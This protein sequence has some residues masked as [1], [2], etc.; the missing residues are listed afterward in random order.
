VAVVNETFAKRFFEGEDPLGKRYC[1]GQPSGDKTQWWTIVGVVGDMRRTGFD[2]DVRPETFFPESQNPDIALNIVARTAGDP[3]SYASALRDAI[4]SVD[5]D[6]PVFDIK[7]MDATLVE[8]T[9][10]RRFNMLLLGIFAA[11]ALLLAA[12]GLYGVMS[13]SVTQ[14]M[15]ELGVRI[16]LGASAR[17]VM[18]LVVGY[19]MRLALVG[20]GVGLVAAFFLTQLMGSLLYGVSATDPATFLLISSLLTGVSLAASYVPARRAMNVDPMIAL[21]YE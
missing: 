15:H 7:T 6:Q 19:A 20:V 9:A 10:Q 3:A 1:Y 12:V 14:R 18:R 11:V 16:A 5:K 17:D 8:M 21:R 4:W 13:Y 2:K